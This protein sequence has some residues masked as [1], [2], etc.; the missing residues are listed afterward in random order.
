[1]MFNDSECSIVCEKCRI[2]QHSPFEGGVGVGVVGSYTK[3]NVLSYPSLPLMK[4]ER[5]TG[6]LN[7]SH[8]IKTYLNQHFFGNKTSNL[9]VIAVTLHL[10]Y[11]HNK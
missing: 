9:D 6:V 7:R 8:I 10:T 11:I 3:E 2:Y 4:N 1:M 5:L